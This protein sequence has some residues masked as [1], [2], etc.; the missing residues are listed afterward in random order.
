M[1]FKRNRGKK[2]QIDEIFGKQ[3]P[4]VAIKDLNAE[5]KLQLDIIDLTIEDLKMI[6]ALKPYV[7]ENVIKIV[8]GFY[9]SIGSVPR[10]REMIEQNSSFERLH[11][12]L[13]KHIVE[14]FEGVI[15][16]YYLEKRS[17]I[18]RIHAHIGLDTTWYLGAF[19]KVKA[20]MFRVS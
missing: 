3:Y 12:T 1:L 4:N 7:E 14:M 2:N 10:F 17:R 11:Q 18:S 9:D 16:Q 13:R 5:Q 19:Q 20:G 6:R 8:D 15:D